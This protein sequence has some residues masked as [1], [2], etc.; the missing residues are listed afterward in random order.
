M[1]QEVTTAKVTLF[2]TSNTFIMYTRNLL[3][4][5]I[6]LASSA[7]LGA[8]E[9]KNI[10]FIICDDLRPEL[11]CYDQK[12]IQS[13]HIDHWAAQS[14]IFDRAYCNIA[15]SG[16]SRAS[17]L[18]GLRPTKNLLQAW[19]SR[20]DVDVSKATTIQE[21]FQK[22]GYTTIANGKIYHHQDEASMKYW[23]KIM[24]PSPKTPMGYHS[25]ENLALMQK[26]KETGKGKRGYFYEHSDYPEKEYLDYQIADQSISDLKNL[27]DQSTPF[28]LAVGF[29]R[30]HLPFVVPQKYWDMY[31]HSKIEIPDNYILKEGSNIPEQAL[32]NWS[33]LRAYSGIPDQGPLDEATA[34]MMIH[35]YYASVSFVDAQIGRLLN[36]LK[37]LDLDKNTTVVLIGDHGWNLGEH[38]TW[39]KHSIMNTCLH[40]TLIINSPDISVPYRCGEITE[41]VDIYPTICEAAGIS[42]PDQ[43]EGTSLIP[44]L[45]S[46][47]SKTKGYAVCRWENGFTYIQGEYFYTE[48]RDKD[49]KITDRMLFDHSTDKDE[50]YNIANRNKYPE[51]IHQ[52]SKKL[53]RNR[54]QNYWK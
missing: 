5:G 21:C 48:W 24:P 29:I 18:T 42:Q 43:L 33:E 10:L 51:I 17:L 35:G 52:L 38:G 36:A 49:D 2:L 19:N 8:K 53:K 50:N 44:L 20:T 28:F 15:V 6:A 1:Q 40:S 34:K 3:L 45:K 16:A 37:E 26:Q 12:H 31:D 13:P 7:C 14:V 32:T 54:G 41:F 11:G 23:D 4:T 27:K 22:E 9:K 46:P 30:P 39:C 47:D 25:D